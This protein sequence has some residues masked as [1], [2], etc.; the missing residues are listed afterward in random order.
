M[1]T[2]T[3]TTDANLANTIKYYARRSEGGDMI[4]ISSCTVCKSRQ[5]IFS[6]E[7]F[8]SEYGMSVKYIL[9]FKFMRTTNSQISDIH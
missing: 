3:C 9:E 5:P 4:Y 7:T 1:R 6:I 8:N 2:N